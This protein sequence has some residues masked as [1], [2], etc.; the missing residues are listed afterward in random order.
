MLAEFKKKIKEGGAKQHKGS[1]FGGRGF[2]FDTS[3]QVKHERCGEGLPRSFYSF[4]ACC[5]MKKLHERLQKHEMGVSGSEDDE[6]QE[7]LLKSSGLMPKSS[8]KEEDDEDS[9]VINLNLTTPGQQGVMVVVPAVAANAAMYPNSAVSAAVQAAA[10][11]AA[12]GDA[13][14]LRRCLPPS[15]CNPPCTS[16]TPFSA[17]PQRRRCAQRREESRRCHSRRRY[18]RCSQARGS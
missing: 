3:E 16:R 12:A 7:A 10:N 6:Q 4:D 8:E 5:S 17:S 15:I 13:A 18:C 9:Q 11:A 14:S 2:K 1:G